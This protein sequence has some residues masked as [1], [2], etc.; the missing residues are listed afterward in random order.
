MS[1]RTEKLRKKLAAGEL[2]PWAWIDIAS[3]MVAEIMADSGFD[4]ILVDTEHNPFNPE[5]LLHILLAFRGSDTV[6]IIRV[7]HNNEIIIKQVLDMGY[8]GVITPQTNTPEETRRAV[9]ACRYPPIGTRGFGPM[10]PSGYYRD[11]GEY[12]RTANES[13]I[14]GIQIENVCGANEIDD[15]VKIPGLDW[16]LI[17]RYDMSGSMGIFCEVEHPDLWKAIKRIS[18]VAKKAGIPFGVPLGCADTIQKT[19]AAGSQLICIG[20]DSIYLQSGA[21]NAL[22]AFHETINKRKK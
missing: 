8:E 11:G 6:P 3:P 17:G 7:P 4:W 18:D 13:I 16:I 15:I 22:K 1:K 10:R 5:T 2:S 14:C 12:V 9:S 20:R 21:D 19:I